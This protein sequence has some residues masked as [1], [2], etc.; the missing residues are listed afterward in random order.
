MKHERRSKRLGVQN[1]FFGKMMSLDKFSDAVPSFNF[2]G[3]QSI[4]TNVGAFCSIIISIVV[5]YYALLKFIQL[6]Q[7]HN[8]TIATFPVETKFDVDN[9]INLND[10]NFKA[11][12]L[13]SGGEDPNFVKTIIRWTGFD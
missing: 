12:F 1:R 11:A 5:L 9:P 8:P 3:D 10:I 4:K 2:K 6:Q 13:F 7:G